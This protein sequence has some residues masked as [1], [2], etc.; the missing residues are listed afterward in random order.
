MKTISQ[1]ILKGSLLVS[2]MLLSFAGFSQTH[3]TMSLK[4]ITATSNAIEY[5][6]YL[7]NDGTTPVKISAFSYGVNFN[8]AILNG[9]TLDISYIENSRRSDLE[10]LTSFSFAIA[11]TDDAG[12]V[13]M[14]TM[15][16]HYDGAS[17]L[18]TG[19]A[20]NAGRIRMK[21]S[22]PWTRNSNPQFTL[23][24]AR[25][26]GLTTTQLVAYLND[27][28]Q[29]VACTPTLK[30][31]STQVDASPMLNPEA[32]QN[33]SSNPSGLL[34]E[35]TVIKIYPNPAIEELKINLSSQSRKDIS[36]KITDINSRLVKQIQTSVSDGM[37]K[38]SIDL[39]ELANG[40]YTIRIMDSNNLNFSQLF[41]KQ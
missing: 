28:T 15:P 3:I 39:R 34:A 13:R 2:G 26:I 33:S 12:Q 14:T 10:G 41:S 19:D 29:L 40:N 18:A 4:N 1:T 21:N 7:I 35:K 6:M 30:T 38:L 36:I 32:G 20:V 25:K 5:D 37:N 16:S 24:E 27:N 31:V 9:G 22:R 8:R 17:E 23:Q 11:Q